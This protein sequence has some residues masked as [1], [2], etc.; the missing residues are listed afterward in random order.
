MATD[1]QVFDEHLSAPAEPMLRPVLSVHWALRLRHVVAISVFCTLFLAINHL[2]LRNTDLWGHV[3]LG[4]WILEHRALPTEDP[5]Q[6]LAEGMRYVDSWWL[7]QVLLAKVTQLAGPEGLCTLFGATVLLTYVSL[8]RAFFLLSNR[9]SVSLASSAL[10]LIV[11]WSR[12]TTL[13]PEVFSLFCFS[14]LLW[15]LAKQS[16]DNGGQLTSR[17]PSRL[18]WL[19]TPLLTI[20][21]TGVHG[22]FV[23]GVLFLA[24]V[25]AGRF[26]EIAWQHRSLKAALTDRPTRQWILFAEVVAAA[27]LLNPFG[28]DLWLDV[29]SFDKNP[30]VQSISEWQPMT[31][32]G[33]GGYEFAVG[34]VALLFVLRLSRRPFHVYDVLLLSLF[35]WQALGHHRFVGW[36]A[37]V[38]AWI[39]TPH[40]AD[41]VDRWFPCQSEPE[42]SEDEMALGTLP[43]GRSWRYLMV[44]VMIVWMTFVFSGLSRPILGGSARARE[45]LYGDMTPYKVTEYLRANPPKGQIYNPQWWGDWLVWDGPKDLRVFATTNLHVLPRQVWNDHQRVS[46]VEA[47]WEGVFDRYAIDT[48]VV[49]KKNQSSVARILRRS[50]EWTPRYEDDQAMVFTRNPKNVPDPVTPAPGHQAGAKQ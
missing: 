50:P 49:D 13:R 33:T 45:S 24:L 9:L 25:A 46:M 7:A 1:P 34:V 37:P 20:V 10:V 40:L 48:A 3:G 36:F 38:L 2:P 12:L 31:W 11:G 14:L 41:F 22:T 4:Q 19:A 28:M 17:G 43:P 32:R 21:W 42:V 39:L 30:V 35:T 6:P 47:G 23:C 8:A 16:H 27:S 15:M 18:L 29:A 26:V 5:L 44:A